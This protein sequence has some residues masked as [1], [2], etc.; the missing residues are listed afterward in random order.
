VRWDAEPYWQWWQRMLE[1]PAPEPPVRRKVPTSRRA[2]RGLD[3]V[4]GIAV[5]YSRRHLHRR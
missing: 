4:K 5:Q 1:A 3:V 2:L